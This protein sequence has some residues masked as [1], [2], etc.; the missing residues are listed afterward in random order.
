MTA[1]SRADWVYFSIAE[2]ELASV[3]GKASASHKAGS[4]WRKAVGCL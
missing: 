1:T 2:A 3:H 4:K